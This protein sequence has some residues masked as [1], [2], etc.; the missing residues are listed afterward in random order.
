M[1]ML[2]STPTHL[3]GSLLA[4]LFHNRAALLGSSVISSL[5]PFH[6]LAI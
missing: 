6:R 1:G 3:R 5:E 2:L 4:L